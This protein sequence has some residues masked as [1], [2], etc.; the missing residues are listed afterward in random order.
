MAKALE[1]EYKLVVEL[2][3][4]RAEQA[5]PQATLHKY[6]SGGVKL[7]SKS[8]FVLVR[9]PLPQVLHHDQDRLEPERAT[10]KVYVESHLSGL[11]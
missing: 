6:V 2:H 10:N 5:F 9:T 7:G 11:L 1:Q 4:L 8:I 3:K